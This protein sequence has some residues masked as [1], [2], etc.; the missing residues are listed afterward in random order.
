MKKVIFV[1]I[2]SL[3]TAI[4]ADTM[5]N[6]WVVKTYKENEYAHQLLQLALDSTIESHGTYQLTA[7]NTRL[8]FNRSSYMLEQGHD[9]QIAY[10]GASQGVN[11]NLIPIKVPLYRGLLGYRLLVANHKNAKKLSK[12][13]C[14]EELRTFKAGFNSQWSD[15]PIFATN[16]LKVET[17]TNILNLYSML[18]YER[19]DYFPRSLREV[20]QELTRFKAHSNTL[21][22][23]DNV[24]LF[25]PHPVY[26]HV[27]PQFESLAKRIEAGLENILLSG[28]FRSLFN[29]YHNKY[30]QKYTPVKRNVIYLKRYQN[31]DLPY[32]SWWFKPN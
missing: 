13:K 15:F 5:R 20:D 11:K 7:N 18:N 10:F 27:S 30:I 32:V 31:N 1:V 8:S 24:A 3:S 2:L 25:Y 29:K 22:V 4:Y 26:Y 28:Q 21:E 16:K 9:F 12:V 23:V 19:F 14:I 6:H 17:A